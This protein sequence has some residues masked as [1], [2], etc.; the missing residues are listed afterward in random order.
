MFAFVVCH[1]RCQDPIGKFETSLSL[2]QEPKQQQ[3]EYNAPSVNN[4]QVIFI[5]YFPPKIKRVSCSCQQ[6]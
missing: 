6:A 2:V 1:Q 4:R 5:S 3:S